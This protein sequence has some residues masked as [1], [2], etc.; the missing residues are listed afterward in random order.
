AYLGL[1][2][3]VLF[4]RRLA[5]ARPDDGAGVAV[6]MRYTLRLLTI[7]QFQRAAALI[8]ACEYLRRGNERP[9]PRDAIL[10]DRAYSIGLWVGG[11]ATPNTVEEAVNRLG[12]DDDP[13]PCQ[14]R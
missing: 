13:T 12:N 6:I 9:E 4:Y 11:G 1:V 3:F 2:A 5:A 7:Q 8:C 14:I 10:G